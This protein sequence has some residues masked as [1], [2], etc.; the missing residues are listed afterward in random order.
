M[1]D[2]SIPE[3]TPLALFC[4]PGVPP[5]P[6]SPTATASPTTTP[7][8]TASPTATGTPST[9]L[10]DC[11][12][13]ATQPEAQAFFEAEGGPAQDPHGLD[14]DGNGVACEDLPGAP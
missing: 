1:F 2:P 7:S 12:D 11:T 9:D 10:R 13:F 8:A 3:A 5:P 14:F 6:P 4:T